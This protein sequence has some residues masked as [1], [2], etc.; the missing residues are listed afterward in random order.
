M[1]VAPHTPMPGRSAPHGELRWSMADCYNGP[2]HDHLRLAG[3]V[4]WV[5]QQQ[6]FPRRSIAKED[7]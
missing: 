5:T 3:M 4:G 1:R 7:R 2:E 6:M